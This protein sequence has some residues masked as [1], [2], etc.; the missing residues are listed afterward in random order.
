LSLFSFSVVAAGAAGGKPDVASAAAQVVPHAKDDGGKKAKKTDG[1]LVVVD[2]SH[3]DGGIA[4]LLGKS[5]GQEVCWIS[6]SQLT[7]VSAVY[8]TTTT[9][10]RVGDKTYKL[11]TVYGATEQTLRQLLGSSSVQCRLVHVAKTFFLPF[12]PNLS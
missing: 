6:T 12:D 10:I 4:G 8:R 5:G 9:T 11:V 2:S 7:R 3:G 1:T